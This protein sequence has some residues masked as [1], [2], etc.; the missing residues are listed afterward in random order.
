MFFLYE[1]ANKLL[2]N[3]FNKFITYIKLYK[4]DLNLNI[5][6]GFNNTLYIEFYIK[7]KNSNNFIEYENE[8]ATDSVSFTMILFGDVNYD[9]IR[10]VLD[11]ITIV[12]DI[13]QTG[14]PLDGT[15]IIAEDVNGDGIINVLDVVTILNTYI[16]G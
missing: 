8:E 6:S 15:Q 2:G 14:V 5:D 11:V 1:T 10:N 3:N 12:Q 16:F 9:A 7:Y 13:L 4:L